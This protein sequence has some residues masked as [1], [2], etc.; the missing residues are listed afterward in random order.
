MAHP[1]S[2]TVAAAELYSSIHSSWTLYAVPI[3]ASSLMT[4]CWAALRTAALRTAALRT[5]ARALAAGGALAA[6]GA[7]ARRWADT[8]AASS[9]PDRLATASRIA[10]LILPPLTAL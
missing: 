10:R 6:I 3:Q 7:D 2:E 1:D 8:A 4:T 9:A 5:A